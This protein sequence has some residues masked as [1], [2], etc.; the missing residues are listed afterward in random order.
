[1]DISGIL[2]ALRKESGLSQAQVAEHCTAHGRAVTQK[3]V[4]KWER[5]DTLPDA[6]QFLLLCGLYNVGDVLSVFCGRDG[7]L[8]DLGTQKLLDFMRILQSSDRFRTAQKK[9]TVRRIPLYDLPVSAGRGQFL[10]SEHYELI[11]ADEGV[12]ASATFAVRVYGDSMMPGFNDGQVIYVQQQQ[13]LNAGEYGIFLL[14]G[15]AY[16][17]R[18]AMGEHT[19][20]ISLNTKYAPIRIEDYDEFRVIGKVIG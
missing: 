17:K 3:A 7:G 2:S 16:L 8:N 15:D 6:E 12:P 4:S 19:E 9:K 14:N 18:L 10:D 13:T 20:L 1:M 11:D 5:G